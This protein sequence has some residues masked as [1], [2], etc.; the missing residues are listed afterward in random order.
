MPRLTLARIVAQPDA[1]EFLRQVLRGGRLGNAY[2]FHGPPGTGKGTAALAFAR[3]ILCDRGA[4]AP[5]RALA[6]DPDLFAAAPPAAAPAPAAPAPADDACGACSQ[7]RKSATLQHPD[8]KFLF[9]VSGEEKDLPEHIGD[10]LDALREDRFHVFRYEKFASIRIG[11]T[12]DLLRELSFRPYEAA[13]RVVVLRDADRM[14]E[15]QYSALLKTLEEPGDSTVWVLTTSRP[16]RLPATIRSRTQKVRFAPIPEARIREF[17]RDEAGT[18]D[19]DASLLAGLAGGSLG[20]A[21]LLRDSEPA[22]LRDNALALLRPAASDPVALWQAVQRVSRGGRE[23]LR[24]LVEFHQL[25][26]RDLLRARYGGDGAPLANADLAAEVTAAAAR[27]DATEVR[28]RLM[29]LEE[30][31]RSIEGNISPDAAL[32]SGMARVAG[33]RMGEREWPRHAVDRWS[34]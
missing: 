21:L 15:D 24:L 25:W 18:G 4:A 3:A 33:S 14:R 26:L 7:C 31:L 19:H 28:R 23:S 16:G 1:V 8:L 12:K 11:M 34:Y 10:T 29:V 22:R 20:R 27:V 30:I 13:R 5:P 2:L 32:F 17:M 6:P 9:P